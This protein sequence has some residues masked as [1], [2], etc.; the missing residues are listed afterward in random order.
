MV[1]AVLE[2]APRKRAPAQTRPPSKEAAVK[3]AG[4]LPRAAWLYIVPKRMLS[5][6]LGIPGQR[7][8]FA[9]GTPKLRRPTEGRVV[10]HEV[11]AI[12]RTRIRVVRAVELVLERAVAELDGLL[13]FAVPEVHPTPR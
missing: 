13:E 12:N 4:G 11:F 1:S 2:E 5:E 10:A 7:A 3:S 9:P 8:A 6:E